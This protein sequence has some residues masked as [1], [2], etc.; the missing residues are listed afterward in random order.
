MWRRSTIIGQKKNKNWIFAWRILK[1]MS[2]VERHDGSVISW[3]II[4]SSSKSKFM[5]RINEPHSSVSLINHNTSWTFWRWIEQLSLSSQL[6]LTQMSMNQFDGWKCM[7]INN[8]SKLWLTRVQNLWPMKQIV[9]WNRSEQIS[10][11]EI[12]AM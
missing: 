6:Q 3:I 2:Q 4:A 1:L 7:S 11:M 5:F 10:E 8:K 12:I 9:A